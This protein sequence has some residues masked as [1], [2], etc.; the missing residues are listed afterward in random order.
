[1]INKI[2]VSA[3]VVFILSCNYACSQ[4]ENV[5]NADEF[6]KLLAATANAQLIDVRTPE[7]FSEG[8]LKNA[9]SMNVN[10]DD[11]KNRSKFLDKDKPVFV[12]CYMG[13]RSAKTCDF[14]RS[15]GF[16]KVY[17][18]KGGYSKWVD[19]NKPV[20]NRIPT[21]PGISGEDFQKQVADGKTL[22]DFNAPWCA[23]CIKMKSILDE[24]EKEFEGKVKVVR[25]DK[26][27]NSQLSKTYNIT[28]LPAFL[29]FENGRLL[30]QVSGFQTKEQ[31]VDLIK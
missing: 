25:F 8:H 18:L 14:L 13:S 5:L 1:M 30:K 3:F 20:D 29:V 12:Y 28:E 16:A 7:E 31:L 4:K 9:L 15:E 26:D 17:D 24:V 23:P 22:V 19:L 27:K 2:I 11:L 6:E 10:S 21:T